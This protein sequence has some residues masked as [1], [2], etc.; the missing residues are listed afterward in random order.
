MEVD[1]SGLTLNMAESLPRKTWDK[2]T[3]V[4]H[5]MDCIRKINTT[6]KAICTL[7]NNHVLNNDSRGVRVL[8]AHVKRPSHVGI[9]VST[10]ENFKLPGAAV[11][12]P[13]GDKMYGA[14]PQYFDATPSVCAY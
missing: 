7:C 5:L 2:E 8:V 12:E 6:G 4:I 11:P 9:L 1:G 3:L 14:P 10:L 13:Q